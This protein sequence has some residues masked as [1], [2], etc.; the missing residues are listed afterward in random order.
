MSCGHTGCTC[1]QASERPVG[2]VEP[3]PEVNAADHSHEHGHAQGGG[4]CC[5]GHGRASE[6]EVEGS[7]GER[8]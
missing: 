7:A 1:G 5:G 6:A 8:V 2:L 4:G 3:R